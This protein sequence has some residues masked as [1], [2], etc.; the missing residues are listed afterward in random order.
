M[1]LY[2]SDFL[3]DIYFGGFMKR[4]KTIIFYCFVLFYF[5]LFLIYCEHITVSYLF[6][7]DITI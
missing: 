7:Y 2:K 1:R 6:L 5:I 4:K 3:E